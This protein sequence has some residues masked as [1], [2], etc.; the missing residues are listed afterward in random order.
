MQFVV[1]HGKMQEEVK[2]DEEALLCN[3]QARY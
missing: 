3:L 2:V 1:R